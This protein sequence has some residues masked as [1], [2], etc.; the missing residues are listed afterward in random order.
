MGGH[1]FAACALVYPHGDWYG[2]LRVSD[3]P[4][5]VRAALAPPSSRHD[6]DD[7]RERLVLW[8]RWRGRLGMSEA[9]QRDHIDTWGPPIVHTAHIA[10]QRR[11]GPSPRDTPHLLPLRFHSHPLEELQLMNRHLATWEQ[12]WYPLIDA[13]VQLVPVVADPEASPW[14]LVYP[15]RLEAEHAMKQRNGG[16]GMS[17]DELHA[18]VQRYMPTYELFSRTADTSRWKEHCMMLR[19]GADRQCI[20]A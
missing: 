20:D 11:A 4:L 3:A 10:P 13:F 19:I 5:L 9:E 8:P 17:D 15:W 1:K 14:S 12:A 7:L 18:F 6:L 16:R 2:N